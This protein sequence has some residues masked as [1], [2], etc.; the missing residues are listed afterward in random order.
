MKNGVR[1][2]FY[3]KLADQRLIISGTL[4]NPIVIKTFGVEQQAGCTGCPA[5]SHI[6]KWLTVRLWVWCCQCYC[7]CFTSYFSLEIICFLSL[8]FRPVFPFFFPFFSFST[9]SKF[10]FS[11][12][13]PL[14]IKTASFVHLSFRLCFRTRKFTPTECST[15]WPFCLNDKRQF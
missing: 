7:I 9:V 11:I 3:G 5:D 15:P 2:S 8:V 10:L 1:Y 12:P 6:V 13:I 4:D 14:I